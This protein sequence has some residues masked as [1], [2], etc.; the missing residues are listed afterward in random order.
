MVVLRELSCRMERECRPRRPLI[1]RRGSSSSSSLLATRF[2]GLG[3]P[4]AS[5]RCQGRR[6]IGCDQTRLRWHRQRRSCRRRRTCSPGSRHSSRCSGGCGTTG[7]YRG[8]QCASCR[9]R[10][11]AVAAA[12]F[13]RHPWMRH[14]GV[15]P[16]RRRLASLATCSV[17]RASRR[18][19]TAR[20]PTRAR[21][22]QRRSA[23]APSRC[24]S[25]L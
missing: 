1:E 15:A 23:A 2:K 8:R 21:R 11:A 25:L 3:T 13:A 22:A 12:T 9:V 17:G 7:W 24:V 18:W 14:T 4:Q 20:A 5:A 10:A 6:R 19:A 16:G